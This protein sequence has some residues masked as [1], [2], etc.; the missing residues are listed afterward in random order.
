MVELAWGQ[1]RESEACDIDQALRP[2]AMRTY[3]KICQS[4]LSESIY[5][6][7]PGLS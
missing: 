3:A 4:A 7:G 6:R 2:R 1:M 5:S